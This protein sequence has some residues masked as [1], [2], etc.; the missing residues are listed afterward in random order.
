MP[1]SAD[2]LEDIKV[3]ASQIRVDGA[4]LL[5]FMEVES[6]NVVSVE[7]NGR[8]VPVIR[9]EG[10][11]FYKLVPASLRPKAVASRLANSRAGAVKN[12]RSQADRYAMLS[13]AKRID[14]EAAV[15][16]C[17]WGIGQVM[18]AH[19]RWL[20]YASAKA[21]EDEAMRGFGG[22]LVIMI[23][24]L[25]KSGILPHLRRGDWS[26]VARIYNGKN[27]AK[28]AYHIKMARAYKRLSGRV[29]VPGSARMLRA[30]SRGADVRE[31]QVLL[32]RAGFHVEPDGDFGPATENALRR[33]QAT[34]AIEVDGVAGPQTLDALA[35]YKQEPAEE[36]GTVPVTKVEEVRDAAK[37]G[38]GGA[39]AVET[40][41]QSVQDAIEKT[42][43][44]P[45]LAHVNTALVVLAALLAIA[46][47]AYAV[48]GILKSRRT[49]RGIE[50]VPDH[51]IDVD[52]LA[53]LT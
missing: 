22:Q 40:A 52:P 45:L 1:F 5:A 35:R 4:K 6:G 28:N 33:F 10:H 15:S 9:W 30:G 42:Q 13:K 39:I 31:L 49:E 11:Y 24:F 26:A 25:E 44:V 37:F 18:G 34:V 41:R 20:G 48:R 46:A 53:D 21:F 29:A 36:P 47:V 32:R 17:S 38:G 19:W 2:Q 16:S 12:P 3:A 51:K 23:K 50:D 8:Q 14:Y 43:D 7:V 27:F